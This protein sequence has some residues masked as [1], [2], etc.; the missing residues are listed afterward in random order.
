VRLARPTRATTLRR[1]PNIGPHRSLSPP[2][3]KSNRTDS[4]AAVA[5]VSINGGN[6]PV[7]QIFRI[8]GS[9]DVNLTLA[10]TQTIALPLSSDLVNSTPLVLPNRWVVIQTNQRL[11]AYD[12][13]PL[14]NAPVFKWT[15]ETLLSE[16]AS[17]N[18]G[19][20]NRLGSDARLFA[21][22]HAVDPDPMVG[23]QHVVASIDPTLTGMNRPF[24]WKKNVR[25][26]NVN[27]QT[28]T[29]GPNPNPPA[30]LQDHI[31]ALFVDDLHAPSTRIA[32]SYRMD[33][34]GS[35]QTIGSYGSPSVHRQDAPA[36]LVDK[37][38]VTS[39]DGGIYG[40]HNRSHV[41]G[42]GAERWGDN[43][44]NQLALRHGCVDAF[45]RYPEQN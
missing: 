9:P 37:V 40:L 2:P 7:V 1:S 14:P 29:I 35:V 11:V 4:A 39:D 10:P 26:R 15:S 3:K 32:W 42:D 31:F 18:F 25:P 24:I 16:G 17:P 45:G 34:A 12:L 6:S 19:L 38:V 21:Q 28:A 27:Y 30:P 23:D 5:L 33:N 41:A 13:S 36:N 8:D 20:I 43:A 22:G 44:S